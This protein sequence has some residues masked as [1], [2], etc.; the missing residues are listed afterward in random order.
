MLV[1]KS[2]TVMYNESI[3]LKSLWEYVRVHHWNIN[4][5]TALFYCTARLSVTHST[6]S[7]EERHAT[8]QYEL[9]DV[10]LIATELN[11]RVRSRLISVITENA[12]TVS[13]AQHRTALHS[14][15]HRAHVH[16]EHSTA[17][18]RTV[19][20][21]DHTYTVSTAQHRTASLR[22]ALPILR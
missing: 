15:D 19:M 20:I 10:T 11:P 13:T 9:R 5:H 17:P 12:H 7:D 2:R 4:L 16:C 14:H 3:P 6:L 18:H 21:T 8:S 22:T 1:H